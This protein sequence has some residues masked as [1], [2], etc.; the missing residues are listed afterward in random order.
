MPSPEH[1]HERPGGRRTSSGEGSD[2][3]WNAGR[4][5]GAV[6]RRSAVPLLWLHQLPGWVTPLALGLLFVAGLM[7]PVG[8]LG[9]V[10]LMLVALFMVWLAYLTWPSLSRQQKA[11]RT[12]MVLVVLVLAIARTLGF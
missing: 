11:P 5:R 3:R 12:L 7:I 6:E 2:R 10:C 8:P 9:A 4:M 1:S